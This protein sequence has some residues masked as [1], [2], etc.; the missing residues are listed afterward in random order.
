MFQASMRYSEVAIDLLVGYSNSK[1][2][3]NRVKLRFCQVYL[4][5]PRKNREDPKKPKSFNV[6]NLF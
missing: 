2:R 6:Y 1:D 5:F 3:S 4:D